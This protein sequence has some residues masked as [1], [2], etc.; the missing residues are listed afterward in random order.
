MMEYE[1]AS[2]YK[3]TQSFTYILPDGSGLLS[4]TV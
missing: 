1:D 3:L 4:M 2:V